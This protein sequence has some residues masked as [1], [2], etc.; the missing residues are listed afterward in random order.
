MARTSRSS[1]YR[2]VKCALAPRSERILTH[3]VYHPEGLDLLNNFA[4]DSNFLSGQHQHEI[5]YLQMIRSSR[6]S[7]YIKF[8]CTLAPR[9]G[10]IRTNLSTIRKAL[11]I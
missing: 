9:S 11:T 2:N 1:L 10:R 7:L 8:T 6:Y 5:F 4:E 3:Y